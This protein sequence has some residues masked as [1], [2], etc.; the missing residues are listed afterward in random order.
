MF[1]LFYARELVN[2]TRNSYKTVCYGHVG[3]VIYIGGSCSG[4][5]KGRLVRTEL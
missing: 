5:S 1:L 2:F 3:R 4:Q